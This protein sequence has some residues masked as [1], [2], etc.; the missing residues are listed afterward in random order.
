MVKNDLPESIKLKIIENF[1]KKQVESSDSES[2]SPPDH[3]FLNG[4]L[5]NFKY[6]SLGEDNMLWN[7]SQSV[8]TSQGVDKTRNSYAPKSKS[9]HTPPLAKQYRLSFILTVLFSAI[10]YLTFWFIMVGVYSSILSLFCRCH[11]SNDVIEVLSLVRDDAIDLDL[12]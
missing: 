4:R 9:I 2:S 1:I 12:M 10:M 5:M 11:D 3:M 7:G 8:L 6:R